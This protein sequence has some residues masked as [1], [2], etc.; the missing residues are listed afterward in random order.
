MENLQSR[1]KKFMVRM[2]N[3]NFALTKQNILEDLGLQFQISATALMR[4]PWRF[5]DDVNE[6]IDFPG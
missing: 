4:I 1:L 2:L 6:D 3:E 5:A